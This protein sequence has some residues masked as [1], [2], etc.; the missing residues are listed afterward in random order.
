[1]ENYKWQEEIILHKGDIT[2]RGGRQSG[3]SWAVAK[4]IVHLAM[5]YAGCKIF[6]GAAAERQEDYLLEKVEILLG[7]HKYRRRKLKSWLPLENGT[8]I[9]KYPLGKFGIYVEG[10][11]SVDFLFIEEAGHVPEGVYDALLPMLAEP[12]RRG[13]GWITLLG[14]TRRCPLKG[15]YY[16]SFQ[17]KKFKQFHI[18]PEMCPHMDQQFLSEELERLG[19]E[20]YDVIYRGEF[21]EA[22]FRYFAKELVLEAV[23]LKYNLPTEEDKTKGYYYLGLDPARFGRSKAAFVTS[24]LRKKRVLFVHAEQFIR[25]KLTELRDRTM[26]LYNIFKYKKILPDDGGIGGGLIDIFE[27]VRE[28]KGKI[29]PLN[30]KSKAVDGGTILKEDL[31][32]NLLRLFETKQ[33]D[34]IDHKDLIDGLLNVEIDEDE[35]II[36]TD[37]SEAAVRAAWPSK[38][39]S[40]KLFAA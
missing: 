30:N 1:M 32:S 2:I 3:K 25:S 40:L 22:A 16:D 4:R 28:L 26:Q 12:R 15:F 37:M 27:E 7:D 14:N 9:I 13:L 8:D 34:I 5:E 23:K 11:S 10:L 20:K 24:Q 29:R 17:N 35:K 31:Y 36:G 6:I 19:K 39:K 18:V 21:N 33:I 38:E